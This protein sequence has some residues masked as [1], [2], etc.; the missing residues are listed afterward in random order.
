M[1]KIKLKN[2]YPRTIGDL[3]RRI[4]KKM[5]KNKKFKEQLRIFIYTWYAVNPTEEKY[6]SLLV[7]DKFEEKSLI[8]LLERNRLWLDF[9]VKMGWAE[10]MP[11][12]YIS[13]VFCGSRLPNGTCHQIPSKPLCSFNNCPIY[14]K[15]KE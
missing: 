4:N 5:Y 3:I 10:I 11:D 15:I 8:S 1:I 13:Y 7:L 2:G 12:F 9:A 6:P 14:T